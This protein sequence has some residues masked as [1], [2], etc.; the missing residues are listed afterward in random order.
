MGK[1]KGLGDVVY[2]ITKYTGIRWLVKKIW[3]E[4]CS[5]DERQEE[6]NNAVPFSSKP[7]DISIYNKPKPTPKL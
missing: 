4:D 5:C 1:I 2:F 7:K 3:G 6:W